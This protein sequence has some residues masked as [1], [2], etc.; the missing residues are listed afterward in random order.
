MSPVTAFII[1]IVPTLGFVTVAVFAI[2]RL[3]L[4]L[5]DVVETLAA[6]KEP[7]VFT[8]KAPVGL[9]L[10]EPM[11]DHVAVLALSETEDWAKEDMIKAMQ[12]MYDETGDWVRVAEHFSGANK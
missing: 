9:P 6:K 4:L 12:E 1:A 2:C 5:R 10:P 7:Q 3:D 11:P 8:A